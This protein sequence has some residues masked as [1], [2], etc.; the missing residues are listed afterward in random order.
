MITMA[1]GHMTITGNTVGIIQED[2]TGGMSKKHMVKDLIGVTQK[3]GITTTE[4]GDMIMETTEM[5]TDTITK[6]NKMKKIKTISL[7]TALV[8]AVIFIS[9]CES[10]DQRVAAANNNLAVAKA[11]LANA[12]LDSSI[13]YNDS[14]AD[15]EA[16]K[17]EWEAQITANEKSL[18]EYKAE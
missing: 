4:T 8:A 5:V 9:S 16:S 6:T 12:K 15:Y 1:K 10:P 7:G 17:K 13:A 11:N 3:T 14:V 18:A 2:I